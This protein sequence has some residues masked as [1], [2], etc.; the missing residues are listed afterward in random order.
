MRT[1]EEV[2]KASEV[3]YNCLLCR[4][5]TGIMEHPLRIALRKEEET[6]RA[7]MEERAKVAAAQVGLHPFPYG[8]PSAPLSLSISPAPDGSRSLVLATL[9]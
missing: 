9:R 3:G 8:G 7:E 2:E 6:R 1:E 5:R 4:P